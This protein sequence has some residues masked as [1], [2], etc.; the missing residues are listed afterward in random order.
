[1]INF[2]FDNIMPL[3]MKYKTFAFGSI[4]SIFMKPI[5]GIVWIV[6]LFAACKTSIIVTKPAEGYV[7]R[8]S[9][10]KHISLINIPMQMPISELE[11]Q[12][13]KYL[14]GVLYED[15]SFTDNGGD[16]LKC[17]VKKYDEI[18][19]KAAENK[20]NITI[21]LDL[22]G[23]YTQLG[24]VVDF[25][26]TL[27]ASYTTAITL[28]D[29]WKLKTETRTQ[30]YEWIRSPKIDLGLFDLPVT[31]IVDA[32]LSGQKEYI[33]RS[34]DQAVKEYVNL[35]EIVQPAF[36]A[37]IEPIHLSE[38]YNTW[39]LIT[40]LEATLTQLNAKN[41]IIHFTM[42]LKANTETFIGTRPTK[43]NISKG[44]PMKVASKPEEDFSMGIVTVIPFA[45]ASEILEKEFVTSGY[46]YKEGKYTIK[47]TKM[48]LY[49]NFDKMVIETGLVGSI[50]GTVYLVGVPYYDANSRSIKMKN[51]DFD[52][53]SKNKLITSA[54]WLGHG[55]LLK[56]IEKN[57]VFPI[58]KEL[59]AA[60]KDA[61]TYL[62]NYEPVRGV[63]IN[64]KLEKLETSDVYLIEDALVAVLN[65]GGRLSV[66]VEGM[67]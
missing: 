58:G 10:D 64:G 45:Q 53:E 35:K 17:V 67:E 39:F 36:D 65:V 37:L 56:V 44:V 50:R 51:L 27:S 66:R 26:G 47:F 20:I 18:K 14:T 8:T 32:I 15:K 43:P 48:G 23:S 22:T 63:F 54:K 29:N 61:Q 3:I 9:Y 40:P 33:N 38:Y 5:V 13:N 24:M 16:N 42:G 62:T 52:V 4:G 2:E 6:V 57:M 34:I 7:A 46:E 41:N 21:P 31:W 25:K 12:T 49:G 60:R 55:A 1:L 30:G 19:F 28:E 11:R 59:D